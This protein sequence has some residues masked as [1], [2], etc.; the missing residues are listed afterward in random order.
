MAVGEQES[1]EERPK[2]KL[3]L[4]GCLRQMSKRVVQATSRTQL[5]V[6]VC[7]SPVWFV[8]ALVYVVI[9]DVLVLS[10]CAQVQGSL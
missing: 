7:W 8:G 6:D 9:G 1:R 5:S 10:E 2:R 4:A 3:S